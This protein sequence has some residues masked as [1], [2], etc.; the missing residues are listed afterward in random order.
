M[1]TN[2]GETPA[3][4]PTPATR[5]G[6]LRVVAY[7]G[8]FLVA[9]AGAYVAV[10]SGTIPGWLSPARSAALCAI[11]GG[12][13]GVLYCLRAVY[14]NACVRDSWSPK[15]LPWYFIRP[16]TSVIA[17]GVSYFVL[18]AGLLILDTQPRSGGSHLGFYVLAFVA[19]L[20]VDKFVGK[21]EDLAQT[22]WGI[23]KSRASKE[24]SDS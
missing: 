11:T 7:L 13:G 24:S 1:P 18:E 17:G 4:P 21:I 2:P 9:L 20:N 22:A 19:G 3:N 8:L 14:L 10:L 16:V 6:I 12:V 5:L 23:E 15:W